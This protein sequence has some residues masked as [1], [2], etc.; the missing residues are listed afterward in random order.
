MRGHV[1]DASL[2]R[3]HAV[4][5][6]APTVKLNESQ[7]GKDLPGGHP[8]PLS[9]RPELGT[10]RADFEAMTTDDFWEVGRP[11]GV[12]VVTTFSTCW[13]SATASPTKTTGTRATFTASRSDRRCIC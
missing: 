10:T 3:Q 8:E 13:R 12:T 11:D 5:Q 2:S 6:P 9:R 1:K 7:G 4:S